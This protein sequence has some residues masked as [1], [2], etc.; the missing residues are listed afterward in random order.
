MRKV[1]ANG[2]YARIK[3]I[4]E[5]V[6]K[7]SQQVRKPENPKTFLFENGL[8]YEKYNQRTTF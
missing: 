7:C 3:K 2:F 4:H 1:V 6:I 5:R 8:F